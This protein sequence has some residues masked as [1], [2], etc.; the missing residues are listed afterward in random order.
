MG[1]NTDGTQ[2]VA[3]QREMKVNAGV[4]KTFDEIIVNA[5]DRQVTDAQKKRES[6]K[7]LCLCT[8]ESQRIGSG[9]LRLCAAT[10]NPKP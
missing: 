5:V 1:G 3:R 9:H 10:L 7:K 4:L 8:A 6:L 2:L